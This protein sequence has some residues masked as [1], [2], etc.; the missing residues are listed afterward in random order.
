MFHGY[1]ETEVFAPAV[2]QAEKM[3]RSGALGRLTWV[4]S[5]EAHSGPHSAHFWDPAS[6][7]FLTKE[8][9]A[10]R[11]FN[12]SVIA[13]ISCDINGPI[14]S[15]MRATTIA[16]PFYGYDPATGEEEKPFKNPENITVM[17]VDNLPGELP[18]D[19]S[20]D[21][22]NQLIENVLHDLFFY[23]SSP[24]LGRAT[25][26]EEGELTERYSYLKG[27]ISE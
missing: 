1:A 20:A 10:H 18:R 26:C 21:F 8:Q 27:Y 17:A 6:P 5:R 12:I 16:D 19:A 2:V 25:I 4:R 7:I 11:D 24:M 3:I 22:G 14:A 13:D 15:T 23:G 9:M